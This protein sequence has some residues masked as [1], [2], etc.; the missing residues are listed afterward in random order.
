MEKV[1]PFL[2][3]QDG[4]AEE[5]IR[6]MSS[7]LYHRFQFMLLAILKMKLATFIRDLMKEDK[8]LCL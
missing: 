8:N 2:M 3:F 1:M 5:A 6:N 7:P 4:K